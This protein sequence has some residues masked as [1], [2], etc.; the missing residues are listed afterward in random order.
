[1]ANKKNKYALTDEEILTIVQG[2]VQAA[3]SW[4][5]SKITKERE[6]VQ[7]YYDGALPARQS[8]GSS[9]YVSSDVYDSL[10]SMKSQLLEVFSGSHDIIRFKANNESE[11]MAARIETSYVA[12]QVYDKNCGFD[13]FNDV[14]DDGLKNRNGIVQVF[15]DRQIVR[16]EHTVEGMSFDDVQSLAAQDDIE[17]D[18]EIDDEL[19]DDP[20]FSGKW[21]RVLDKSRLVIE[22][23]PPEEYFSEGKKKKRQEGA[24][25]RRVVKTKADLIN[26]GYPKEL[27]D[28]IGGDD[29]DLSTN[30]EVITRNEDTQDGNVADDPPQTE[31]DQITLFETFIP[32]A[33]KGDGSSSLYRIVHAGQVMF[34]CDEVEEDNFIIFTPLRKPH[35][36]YGNNFAKRII[37]TQNARTVLTRAVLDH[38]ATTVNPRWQ[39]LNGALTNPRELLDNRLRGIVNVKMRDGIAPLAYPNLNPFV[40][41]TLEMLKQN[42]EENTGISSLSQGLNK[43]A[44]SSQNS[45]GLVDNLVT[46]SQVRQKVIARNFAQFLSDLFKMAR[47][48]IVENERK[49]RI[50][51]FDNEFAKVNP[52]SWNPE[53]EVQV[54][55]HVGYGEQ[56]KEA[57]KFAQL[58]GLLSTDPKASQ[59][60][61]PEK[62][63]KLLTDGMRKN[64]FHNVSD[65]LITPEQVKP[66]GPDP[67]KMKELE[68]EGKQA[69]AAL[70]TAQTNAKKVDA[71]IELEQIKV[72]VTELLAAI[73]QMTAERDADRKDLDVANKVNVSQRELELAEKVD[74][75][76]QKAIY[77]A[78][79]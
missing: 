6:R 31:L 44:I 34:D 18:F 78:N 58:W 21:T 38:T 55:L 37:P 51:E 8:L 15:W 16:D 64:G 43:D 63:F 54:S 61:P 14:I 75:M 68:N 65:Y 79:S 7:R 25:G 48:L 3:T 22:N 56:E 72:Q 53:R 27:V 41:Q 49:E 19:A 30:I 5:D 45:E 26:E 33:L 52:T 10:E 71:Q 17:V 67:I 77:S 69:D 4:T 57:A 50:F 42:K 2:K 1:M 70:L 12:L 76:N 46:L 36:Q 28:K 66:P 73:K 47:K 62:Q 59:F 40:F 24:R 60:C 20:T 11:V 32:L 13:I 35:S 39:V 74:P 23:V 9:S 29:S